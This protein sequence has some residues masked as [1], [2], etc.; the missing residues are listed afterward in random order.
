[1]ADTTTQT[2]LPA[3]R[4]AATFSA[5]RRIFSTSATEEPPYF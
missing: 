4:A 2:S 3:R 5:T 1:M